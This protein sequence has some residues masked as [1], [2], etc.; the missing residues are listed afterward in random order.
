MPNSD[1]LNLRMLVSDLR[2]YCLQPIWKSL[3]VSFK[4]HPCVLELTLAPVVDG[5]P[6]V[7]DDK[8]R[9]VDVVLVQF[10]KCVEQFLLRELLPE[11]IP[12]TL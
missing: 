3:S 4:F 10:V 1:V 8:T 5:L 11:C 2:D 6:V 12:S 9:D 7:V